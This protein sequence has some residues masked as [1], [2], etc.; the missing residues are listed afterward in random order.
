MTTIRPTRLCVL[1]ALAALAQACSPA[2]IRGRT[3]SGAT[4]GTTGAF[5][6]TGGD[7]G[8]VTGGDTGVPTT[9]DDG[10]TTGGELT[11]GGTAGEDV[12]G[13]ATGGGTTGGGTT[14]GGTTGG[15]TGGTLDCA[16][17]LDCA[18][19]ANCAEGDNTCFNDALLTCAMQGSDS[20]NQTLNVYAGCLGETCASPTPGE[21]ADLKCMAQS[22]WAAAASCNGG[23]PYMT[24][25]DFNSCLAN[26]ANDTQCV[27]EQCL[28]NAKASALL[29]F[30]DLIDCVAAECPD[31]ADTACSENA[32]MGACSGAA[33]SCLNN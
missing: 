16:G 26:C 25:N 6:P 17:I 32:Q 18:N 22:C 7:T 28:W 9:G 20:G 31:P 8:A 4:T 13:G 27:N 24:C 11:G 33:Q 29:A 5:E 2:P 14:G 12:T 30:L 10:L 19:A 23:N 15:G 1:L 21:P 3:S